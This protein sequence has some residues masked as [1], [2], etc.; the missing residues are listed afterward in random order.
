MTR[1]LLVGHG[2]MGRLVE[3]LAPDYDCHVGAIVTGATGARGIAD[4]QGDFDVAIDFTAPDAVRGN[5]PVLAA[6]GINVVIGTTGWHTCESEM[7]AIAAEHGIGVLAASNFSIGLHIFS[8]AV[9]NAAGRFAAQDDVG[10]W[11][12]EAH[13]SGK[14]DAPSGT[15]L[16]LQQIMRKAGYTRD[17]SVS[18]TRAGAIPGTHTVGFDGPSETVTLTHTV[19]DRAVFARGALEVTCWL[20]G[21]K[22]WFTMNEFLGH[23]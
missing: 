20:V 17:I 8:G 9:A 7:R 1:I 16:T 15:A 23:T 18:S 5:L 13:H 3:Q 19:R 4:A 11:I 6:R 14:K 10:A 12:H 2:R 22:G 21:K